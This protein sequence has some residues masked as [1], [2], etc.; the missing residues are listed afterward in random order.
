MKFQNEIRVFGDTAFRG[1]CPTESAE[2][3]T[4]FNK[5]RREY[6]DTFG[7]IALH[8]R[9][10]G[11]RTMQQTDRHKA[12]GMTN[13]AADII[14]PASPAFVCELKRL[15]HTKCKWQK[16]Q[17]EFLIECQLLGA[18]TCVA[19]GWESA[20]EAFKEWKDLLKH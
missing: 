14:I 5:L 3:M 9:N 20:W 8:P 17:Q 2:Q 11:L 7:K 15:D 13:G 10:E 1:S 16:G 19:L 6:P 18:F 4:F 12:E